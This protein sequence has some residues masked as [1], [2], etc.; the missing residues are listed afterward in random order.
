MATSTG[1]FIYDPKMFR[2]MWAVFSNDDMTAQ[3]EYFLWFTD[4]SIKV[5]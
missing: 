1:N 5:H 3:L 2:F 4:C